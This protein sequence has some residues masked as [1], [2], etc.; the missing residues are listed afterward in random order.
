MPATFT[1]LSMDETHLPTRYAH[2]FADDT[3]H[4]SSGLSRVAL[5]SIVSRRIFLSLPSMRTVGP[6]H[7]DPAVSMMA[8][9]G[10]PWDA[11][12]AQLPVL[13]GAYLARGFSW[14]CAQEAPAYLHVA[15]VKHS[16]ISAHTT[17]LQ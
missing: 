9:C 4:T 14:H 6:W 2:Q 5:P 3:Q 15:V 1:I 16:E 8:G 12:M 7:L 11:L 13:D 10:W 17:T